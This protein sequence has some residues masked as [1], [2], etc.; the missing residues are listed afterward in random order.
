M[1]TGARYGNHVAIT[2][3]FRPNVCT[4]FLVTALHC[5][6]RVNWAVRVRNRHQ[7]PLEKWIN[8]AR[9]NVSARGSRA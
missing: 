2:K 9:N 1:G 5:I 8:Q 7:E 6:F 4:P 3:V